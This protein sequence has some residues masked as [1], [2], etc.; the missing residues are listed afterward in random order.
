MEGRDCIFL[1]ITY[2]LDRNFLVL[3]TKFDQEVLLPHDLLCDFKKWAVLKFSWREHHLIIV[4]YSKIQVM[5][6]DWIENLLL[7]NL[8]LLLIIP[9]PNYANTISSS[10]CS[11]LHTANVMF[12]E[13]KL[14]RLAFP[15]SF[16]TELHP[17]V[18]I[19][20]TR[21]PSMWCI[22]ILSAM[23]CATEISSSI[24]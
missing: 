10:I 24:F 22:R 12:D 8:L 17:L 21:L 15:L 13:C 20:L 16:C 2:K 9:S 18:E 11:I 7:I 4:S 3:N 14:G 19:L 23:H 1:W 5:L 6:L